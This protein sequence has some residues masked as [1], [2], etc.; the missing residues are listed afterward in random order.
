MMKR[1]PFRSSKE[2]R[3]CSEMC[4]VQMH[5]AVSDRLVSILGQDFDKFFPD[6]N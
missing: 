6:G 4:P 1:R 2:S 3:R 5:A